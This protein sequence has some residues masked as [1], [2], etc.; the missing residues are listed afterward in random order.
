MNQQNEHNPG[1]ATRE[2]RG[3]PA[4]TCNHERTEYWLGNTYCVLCRK[5]LHAGPEAPASLQMKACPTCGAS[6]NWILE[7]DNGHEF[8]G[9]HYAAAEPVAPGASAGPA[10]ESEK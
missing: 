6:I 7:C 2:T 3:T 5:W 9:P 4:D 1:A 10:I 8:Q